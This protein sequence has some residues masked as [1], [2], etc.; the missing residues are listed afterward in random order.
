MRSELDVFQRNS[1]PALDEIIELAAVLSNADYAYLGSMDQNR[2]WFKSRF[3][4]RAIEQPRWSTGCQ[5][6][7]ELGRPLLIPDTTRDGHF[8]PSGIPV[9]GT[10]PCRSYAGTP[11]IDSDRQIVGSLAMLAEQPNRFNQ[12]HLTLL[13]VLGRQAMTRIELYNRIASQEQAQRARMR[14]ERASPPN[15]LRLRHA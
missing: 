9:P 13:E 6:M 15:A 12:E 11:L 7:L 8:P 3:G 10:G 14:S 2:L 4:F 1:D 5:L